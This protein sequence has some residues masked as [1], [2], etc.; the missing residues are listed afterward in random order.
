M[1]ICQ[2]CGYDTDSE[3][4]MKKHLEKKKICKS[5]LSAKS[6]PP[7]QKINPTHL[8]VCG[9]I[10]TYLSGLYRHVKNIYK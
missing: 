5:I 7:T 1:Y 4:N 3:E 6:Y 10:Y 9:N 2:R 8:C